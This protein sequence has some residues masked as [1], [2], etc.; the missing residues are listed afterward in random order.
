MN[1]AIKMKEEIEVWVR[2]RG[3][4]RYARQFHVPHFGE[5]KKEEDEAE[6]RALYLPQSTHP[7]RISQ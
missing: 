7:H 3:R 1:I 4:R 5:R 6:A 2:E